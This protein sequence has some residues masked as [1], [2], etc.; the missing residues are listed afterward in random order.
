MKNLKSGNKG[1]VLFITSEKKSYQI[2]GGMEY[3]SEGPIFDDMKKWNPEKY[4][5]HGAA[6]VRIET[7]YS[8]SE[9]IL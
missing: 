6:V 7:I 9:K 8:G 1:T 4:P 5:G 2:K 3:H